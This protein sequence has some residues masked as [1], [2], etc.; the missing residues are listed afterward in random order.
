M[1]NYG[2]SA[3]RVPA[4]GGASL[5]DVDIYKFLLLA[6]TERGIVDA[7]GHPVVH[8]QIFSMNDFYPKCGGFNTSYYGSY[9]ADSFF[10]E[11]DNSLDCEM[12]VISYVDD[13]AVQASY[14]ILDAAPI[15]IFDL[16]S[17]RKGLID[18]SA[19][20]NKIAAKITQVED[21]NFKM[22][23]NIAVTDTSCV[24]NNVD[25]LEV[26]NYI[27]FTESTDEE[28][29]VITAID[30]ATKTITFSALELAGGF[31]AA[32]CNI[33]R[34]D[35]KLEI[36]VKNEK[37]NYEKKEVWEGPFAQSDTIG[38]ASEV[39]DVV[40]GSE[41]VILTVDD[42][43][44]SDP[45]DQIPAA[46]TAWTPLVS[47]SDGAAAVD[48][49]WNTLAET[50]LASTEF[51]IM[52]APESSSLVH[53][54]NMVEFCTTYY[55]GMF[56]AAA[57][58][59]ATKA[60][61]EDLCGSLRG[62]YRFGMLPGDKWVRVNDPSTTNGKIDIPKVGMDAASWF[63]TYYKF[64]ESKVAAGNKTE[65]IL[66]T[67]AELLD[68]NG[69]V[70]DDKEGV[71]GRLIRN[72]SVN[73]CRYR[74]GIGITNNSART[75]STDDGYKFQNQIMAFILYARS[76]VTYLKTVEQDK[77]GA[78]AQEIHKNIIW[79]YMHSKFTSGHLFSGFKE[80]G[81]KT[82]FNDVCIIKND[83]TVN[84]LADIN[85]GI[86]Q[87]FLQFVSP[88]PIE[89]NILSLASAGVTTVRS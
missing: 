4:K 83:F 34:I 41:Y 1:S 64:G 18:K 71:G 60:I 44:A 20:G 35:W 66:N 58:N 81:T 85:N 14:V 36:A 67:N 12:K 45:G 27:R 21:F 63:N 54:N 32:A 22:T 52:T 88:P 78:N 76:I 16:K 48:A 5:I 9:I 30:G 87:T 59:G 8:D 11:L 82:T 23:A 50:Y 6:K 80:D 61:L 79:A 38:L 74:R 70:H 24:L 31:T 57:S 75:F 37:G 39:N 40:S 29:K 19:F 15:K 77:A 28:V 55:R 43:N 84:T 53:N 2:S 56:Y 42:T 33:T 86:E 13:A 72:Y 3:N 89:E 26:G 25:N 51:T 7:D 65:M 69:L 68:S 49:D 17:G 46:L 10:K 62:S 73:I 47:G